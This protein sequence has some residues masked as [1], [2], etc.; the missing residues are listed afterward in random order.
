MTQTKIDIQQPSPV[1]L[2]L[3]VAPTNVV[4]HTVRNIQDNREL[5]GIAYDKCAAR[6]CRLVKWFL[7]TTGCDALP[8]ADDGR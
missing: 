2:Q 8:G 5:N 1:L 4:T 7:P 6:L 3:C